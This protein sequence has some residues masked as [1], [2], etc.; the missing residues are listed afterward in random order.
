AW[1]L[2]SQEAA[3][4]PDRYNQAEEQ[5]LVAARGNIARVDL[6]GLFNEVI[7]NPG[8]YGLTN[9]A[10]MAC[11]TGVSAM[12]CTSSTTGFS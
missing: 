12:D 5:G 8:L 11:P 3:A 9:K 10:G 1:Q 6:N 2:L 4:L 7:A